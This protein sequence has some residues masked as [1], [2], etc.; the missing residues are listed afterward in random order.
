LVLGPS[1]CGKSK[2]L[3]DIS[4]IYFSIFF[5]MDPDHKHKDVIEM[6]EKFRNIFNNKKLDYSQKMD[7]YIEEFHK[8]IYCRMLIL[9]IYLLKVENF[10]PIDFT[11]IQFNDIINELTKNVSKYVNT[12]NN[13]SKKIETL[14]NIIK[15]KLGKEILIILDEA[16]VLINGLYS[17][18]DLIEISPGEKRSIYFPIFNSISFKINYSINIV[19]A[20]T[21]ISINDLKKLLSAFL[22]NKT[23]KGF[24]AIPIILKRIL[25]KNTSKKLLKRLFDEKYFENEKEEEIKKEKKIEEKKIIN[26]EKK[27]N[28]N[29]FKDFDEFCNY[30][31]SKLE[32]SRFRTYTSL[33]NIFEQCEDD[34]LT[35]KEIVDFHYNEI[36]NKSEKYFSFFKIFRILKNQYHDLHQQILLDIVKYYYFNEGIIKQYEDI[37]LMSY[38]LCML[39]NSDSDFRICEPIIIESII[40]YFKY[41]NFTLSEIYFKQITNNLL[42]KNSI[43]G[44]EIEKI[45]VFSLLDYGKNLNTKKL[46]INLIPYNEPYWFTS[47][48]P[49]F[50]KFKNFKK[51]FDYNKDSIDNISGLI[52]CKILF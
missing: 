9:T 39:E 5:D 44:N 7:K 26:Q 47:I 18:S 11:I 51:K 40:N 34:T 38:G 10:Q 42:L 24:S 14:K 50:F 35:I 52:T 36:T 29:N 46:F 4:R 6:Y 33:L 48:Y 49:N 23:E 45:I 30:T 16:N 2:L 20:G 1:G 27:N 31:F 12:L 21:T 8:K 41:N 28:R 17:F 15:N 37:D 32:N 19:I 43:V 13:F 3:I 22:K 25:D